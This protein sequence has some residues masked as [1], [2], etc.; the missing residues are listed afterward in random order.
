MR[1]ISVFSVQCAGACACGCGTV[2]VQGYAGF[3]KGIA[4]FIRITIGTGD[5]LGNILTEKSYEYAQKLP[6]VFRM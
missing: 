3:Y 4:Q 1:V 6:R 5:K 2:L